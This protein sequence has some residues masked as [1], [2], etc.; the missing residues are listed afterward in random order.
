MRDILPEP[1]FDAVQ[2]HLR[3]RAIAAHAGWDSAS[4][5]EDALTGD[6]CGALRS[7]WT[8]VRTDTGAWRWRV[9]YKKF[10][11]RG[12][13][14]FEKDAGADGIVQVEVHGSNGEIATKGVLF[15][16][17]KDR[18]SSRSDLLGQV[19]KMEALAPNGSAV[20]EFG[21]DAYRAAASSIVLA[22]LEARPHRIPHPQDDIG[23]YLAGQFLPCK[24]GLR[25]MYYDAVRKILVVPSNGAVRVIP[26]SL[27]HRV[28]FDLVHESQ[29]VGAEERF[30]R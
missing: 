7:S 8:E 29:F 2:R 21:P 6:F 27:R 30:E 4:E 3:E 25:G 15:Q 26:L 9:W 28:R 20:F 14:A 18:G 1:L 23:E 17:K 16:A 5:D 13:K 12:A 19:R 10:R 24:S 11:G 22:E